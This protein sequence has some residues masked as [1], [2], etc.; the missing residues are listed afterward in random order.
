[1]ARRKR[2]VF[3]DEICTTCGSSHSRTRRLEFMR[4]VAGAGKPDIIEERPCWYRGESGERQFYRDL[5]TV[6]A[7]RAP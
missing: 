1:M 2:Q 6:R 4:R 7:E 5:A 3:I